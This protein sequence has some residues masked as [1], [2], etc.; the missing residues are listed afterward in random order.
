MALECYNYLVVQKLTIELLACLQTFKMPAA[1]PESSPVGFSF[2]EG[3]INWGIAP[4][5]FC[6]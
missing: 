2:N 5:A 3:E 6:W 1:F 4:K